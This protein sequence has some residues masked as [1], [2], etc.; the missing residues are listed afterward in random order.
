M[1]PRMFF[2]NEAVV[3]D[4]IFFSSVVWRINVDALH[5]PGESHAEIAERVEIVAFN[6]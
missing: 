5:L 2:V 6:D 1:P 4:E 3:I